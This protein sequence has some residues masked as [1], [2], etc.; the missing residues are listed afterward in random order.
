MSQT[1]VTGGIVAGAGVVVVVV[2]GAC[3]CMMG[4]SK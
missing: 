2:G 3:V 1:S 4:T